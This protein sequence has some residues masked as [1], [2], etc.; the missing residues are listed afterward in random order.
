MK[1]RGGS[2]SPLRPLPHLFL[3][4]AT[5]LSS[6]PAWPSRLRW[7]ADDATMNSPGGADTCADLAGIANSCLLGPV[8]PAWSMGGASHLIGRSLPSQKWPPGRPNNGRLADALAQS[9]TYRSV[10]A[11]AATP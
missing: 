5:L 1:L 10:E 11:G 2:D 3:G 7:G 4:R 6:Y 9:T 8:P